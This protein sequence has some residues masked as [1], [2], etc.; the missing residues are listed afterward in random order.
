MGRQRCA[1][2]RREGQTAPVAFREGW[3]IRPDVV[4]QMPKPMKVPAQGT[5][6]YTYIAVSAPFKEDTWVNAGEIRPSDRSHV[7]HVIA[8]VRPKGSKWM[9]QAQLGTEPWAPGPNRQAEMVKA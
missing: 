3:N 8:M 9:V 1:G 5:V 7:H 6:E 4:F 2:R